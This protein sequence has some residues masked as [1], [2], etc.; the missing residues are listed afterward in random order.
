MYS[1]EI[2]HTDPCNT[3]PGLV[4]VDKVIIGKKIYFLKTCFRLCKA[5]SSQRTAASSTIACGWL[6]SGCK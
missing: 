1:G 6:D 4:V 2:L 5:Y 3:W